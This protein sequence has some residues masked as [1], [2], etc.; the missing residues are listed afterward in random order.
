MKN[1]CPP[2]V[3]HFHV[4]IFTATAEAPKSSRNSPA[5]KRR[6]DTSDTGTC[7]VGVLIGCYKINNFHDAYKNQIPNGDEKFKLH[8]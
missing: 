8:I 4:Y 3:M 6:A 7:T 2:K 5:T 1:I